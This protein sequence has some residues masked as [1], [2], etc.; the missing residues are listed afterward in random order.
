MTSEQNRLARTD[1]SGQGIYYQPSEAEITPAPMVDPIVVVDYD[2]AWPAL[3]AALRAPVAATLGD[4]A[5]AIEHVGSTAVPGLA[6]KPIIDLDVAIR[7]ETRL[8]AA[9]ERLA[10]LGYAYEGHKGIPG[11]A[12]FAWPP[13]A[14]RHHLYVC[15][16]DSV[17]YRCHLLFRDYLRTHPETTAAYAA[18]KR[19]LAARYRL[20]RDAY[21]EAK[22]PFVHVTMARA[23]VWA[24][25]TGWAIPERQ[26]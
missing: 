24:Q 18:L 26:A 15:A 25:M 5:V 10:R 1:Q 7:T 11:R 6:A 17:E 3:F 13:Q 4:M 9:I 14:V 22:G 23:E 16:L 12:A 2:P 8:P 21:A 19:Q 20:Q